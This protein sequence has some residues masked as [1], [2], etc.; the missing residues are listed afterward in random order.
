MKSK[1]NEALT[2]FKKGQLKEAKNLC[3]EIL[4]GHPN[5]FDVLHILGIINFREKNFTESK[6]LI[7]KAIKIKPNSFEIHN[8]FVISFSNRQSR[9]PR[10]TPYL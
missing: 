9:T 3:L 4:K 10:C 8:F 2:F 7:E 5:N 6:N 1:F